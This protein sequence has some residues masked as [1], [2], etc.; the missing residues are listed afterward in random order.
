MET[1][2]SKTYHA[3]VYLR[4]SREDGDVAEGSRALSNSISNQKE[5]VM[6]YL[7]S[8]AEIQVYS[9]YTDDGWSGVD[10]QRPEFQRMLSDIREGSVDCV[11]V[12]D[13][14][15][16]GRNYI[17]SGRYIEKIFPMLGVRF[18]AV[19][20]GYDSLDGQYGND[21]VIPFKNLI[22]EAYA[23]DI[24]KKICSTFDGLF[25]KGVY[26]ATTAA[27]G[28][29]KDL[30]DSHSLLVDENVRDVVVRIFKE[31]LAG[32]SLAQIARGL[33]ADGIMAPSVYWQSIGVIHKE[34]Y[35]NLWEG[36]QV[37]RILENVVY[38]GDVEISK[39]YRAYYRGITRA[40][41]RDKGERFYVEGHHEAIID[42]ETFD[43]VQ[44]LMQETKA[45]YEAARQNLGGE[46]NKREDKLQGLLYC[47]H[48]GNK[49]NLY[50]KT[51][52]LVNG[53]GHYST[54]VCRRA[55]TYGEADPPKNVKAEAMERIVMELLKAHMAV[56]VDA[57]E[58]MRMLN[59]KPEA[60]EKRSALKKELS[61]KKARREKI[62]GF[63]QA[64]YTDFADGVFSEEEYLE[65]KAGYV[66][67]LEALDG[68]M[69][70]LKE[71]MEG[72]A[73]DYAGNGEMA[74]A[75]GKYLGAE[76]LTKEM[77]QTFIRKI[78][79]YG[80][81]RFEVEYT[82]AGELAELVEKGGDGAA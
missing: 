9:V 54:Y 19:N 2:N 61:G 39:T 29:R 31:R 45:G 42:H 1:L 59:Q 75:F 55:A 76:E 41:S 73:L 80:S 16:F 64:L 21:M 47:G 79:C 38:T 34:K 57:R 25:E 36:K 62:G 67:E 4:L 18:I 50:R 56:Y 78:V 53:Y 30:E 11:V 37:R 6:D 68:E 66:S 22:N 70:R 3:A 77:A 28:Y 44:E 46:R 20:D 24:S 27:Y 33:N 43:R 69:A 14:S 12:K 63:I 32:K 52:K 15:R 51:V 65:M 13:L 72:L 26:L 58:R 48:C 7:R 82:F 10:F 8:H 81:D 71:E 17:E 40:V 49:M 60:A 23:K 35:R 5:L 74:A